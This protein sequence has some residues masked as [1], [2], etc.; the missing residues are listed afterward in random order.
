MYMC[1]HVFVCIYM[2]ACVGGH[3][4]MCVF[5][6]VFVYTLKPELP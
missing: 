3:V 2:Y 5:M 4:S 6:S 1:V